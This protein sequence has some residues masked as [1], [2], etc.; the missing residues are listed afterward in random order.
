MAKATETRDRILRAAEDVVIRDGVGHLTLEAAATEAGVS[1]GGVL[2]HFPTRNALVSAMVERLTNSFD[3]D[4]L[5]YGAGAKEPGSF[6]RAYL[7]AE[8]HPTTEP[9]AAHDKRL[10]G[11]LLAAAATDPELLAPL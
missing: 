9:G 7:E 2:Y 3:A 10:G 11:A 6:A 1:K 8:V 4:L 5:R